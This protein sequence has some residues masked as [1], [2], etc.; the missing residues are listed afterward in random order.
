MTALIHVSQVDHSMIRPGNLTPEYAAKIADALRIDAFIWTE[1][2]KWY[3]FSHEDDSINWLELSPGL[4]NRLQ[5]L[6]K[7]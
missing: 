3:G 6:F 2:G 1:D 5:T 4:W 7:D